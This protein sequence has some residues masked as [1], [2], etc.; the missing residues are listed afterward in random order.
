MAKFCVCQFYVKTKLFQQRDNTYLA[1]NLTQKHGWLFG[2]FNSH[3]LC[4]EYAHMTNDLISDPWPDDSRSADENIFSCVE[5]SYEL[6][7]Y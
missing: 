3:F 7:Q 4:N 6:D 2:R 5:D 1:S